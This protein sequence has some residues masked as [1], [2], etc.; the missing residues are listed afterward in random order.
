M[1]LMAQFAWLRRVQ[2]T[3][4]RP[5]LRPLQLKSWSVAALR[6]HWAGSPGRKNVCVC[7]G[8]ALAASSFPAMS[9]QSPP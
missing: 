3:I 4:W 7:P 5:S 6:A 9:Q 2:S 8:W 1:L